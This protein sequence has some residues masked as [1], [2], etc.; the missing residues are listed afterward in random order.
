M[1]SN[2]EKLRDNS[3]KVSFDC[4]EYQILLAHFQRSDIEM[5]T[6]VRKLNISKIHDLVFCG[7]PNVLTLPSQK[8]VEMRLGQFWAMGQAPISTSR[9]ISH[10]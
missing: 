10:V 2:A 5:T 4:Y 6:L 7:Q 3:I 9:I 1:N 8:I